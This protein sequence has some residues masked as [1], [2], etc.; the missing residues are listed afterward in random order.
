MQKGLNDKWNGKQYTEDTI[1]SHNGLEMV[2]VRPEVFIGRRG[3]EGIYKM[4]LEGVANVLD[5]FNAGRCENMWIEVD[6][7]NN[8]WKVKDDAFGIPIGKFHDI[9]TQLSTGGKFGKSSYTFSV[10][11]NAMGLKLLNALSTKFIADT[12]FGDKHGHF[13]SS[14]GI[15]DEN[16]F[17]IEDNKNNHPTGTIIQW[18]P[19]IEIFEDLSADIT[20]YV[21]YI[22][23]NAY[24]NSGIKV[25]MIWNNKSYEFYHPEG[26]LGYFSEKVIKGHKF[27]TVC[28]EPIFIS[29][30]TSVKN[31]DKINNMAYSVFLTWGENVHSEFV[32]SYVNGLRTVNHGAHVTGVHMAITKSIKD[33]IDKNNVIPK[34]A[35][36]EINGDDVRESLVLLVAANH[37]NPQYTTQVKDAM[38]NKDIQFFTSSS[39]YPALQVWLTNHKKEAD[40]ICKLVIRSA[41]AREAAKNAK[42]N[43]IKANNKL[44]LGNLNLDKYNG[45]RSRNPEE[46]ELF[47]VEGDSAGGSAKKAR[48]SENQAV[49]RIRGK[50]Q[51]VMASK[52]P[53]FSDEL[54]T[55]VE[56]MGCGIGPT[57]NINKLR[58]HKIVF[59]T[60]ADPDGYDIKLL[61]SGFFFK[62]YRPLIEAGYIYEAMPPLFQLTFGSGANARTV[63][64]PDQESFN[65]AISHIAT[66]A[67]DLE[68]LNGTKLSKKI[69]KNYINALLDFKLF[70][71]Q[72]R[73]Q[74]NVDAELLEYIVRYYKDICNKDFRK[75]EALNYTCTIVHEGSDHLHINVD[76]DYEHYFVTLDNRFYQ[77]VYK[78]IS[79]RLGMIKLMDIFFVGK[80]TGQKYG[81]N[82][83]RNANFIEGLLLGRGVKVTRVKGLGESNAAELRYYMF[84]ESTRTIRQLRMDDAAKAAEVFDMCLGKA[85]E[86]RKKFCMTGE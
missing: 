60:D 32:E 72:M 53:T 26:L 46:S 57:F 63:F 64:L 48:S 42:D 74:T 14:K 20:R 86:E 40:T 17:I 9:V 50:I 36:F 8:L 65:L 30:K 70:M 21:N 45:C 51:N 23:I 44:G 33:Y 13:E 47:I 41:K 79:E 22:D 85:I 25:H 76:R 31:G 28:S 80:K 39:V 68:T 19:D 27:R 24:I 58:F 73:D 49:F 71:E 11:L 67:F 84:N 75:M 7:V 62:Y 52:S 18:S 12:W 38:E 81:G 78:P 4:F 10:G 6:T 29:N 15:E 82:S 34:N 54:T 56:V 66:E 35:K 16:A 61:L 69:A 83:W 77:T 59:G 43:I 1:E 55:L 3:P 5:E 37:S 2:R